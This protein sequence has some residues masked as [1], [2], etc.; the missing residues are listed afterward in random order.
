MTTGRRERED[1]CITRIERVDET[2][3]TIDAWGLRRHCE[4]DGEREYKE[5]TDR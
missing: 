5:S 1:V 4:D 3:H 2:V